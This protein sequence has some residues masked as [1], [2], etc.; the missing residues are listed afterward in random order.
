M[1]KNT[2]VQPKRRGRPPKAQK[3]YEE[4][5]LSDDVLSEEE[6]D[7]ALENY[8]NEVTDLKE[9]LNETCKDLVDAMLKIHGQTAIINLL[10]ETLYESCEEEE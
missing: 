2:A 8:A 9:S 1:K 6:K 5:F 7:E 10:K 3:V 4:D